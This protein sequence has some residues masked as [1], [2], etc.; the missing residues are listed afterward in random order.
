[1]TDQDHDPDDPVEVLRRE[2]RDRIEGNAAT[3]NPVD[4]ARRERAERIR[5]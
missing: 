1:M 5:S 4:R 3:E 2:H